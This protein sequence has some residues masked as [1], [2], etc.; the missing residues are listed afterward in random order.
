M[1]E[2]LQEKEKENK[3]PADGRVGTEGSS[4]GMREILAAILHA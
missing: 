1:D 2:C 3:A 4:K